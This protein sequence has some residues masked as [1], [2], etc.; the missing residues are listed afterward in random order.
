MLETE[1]SE[2]TAY[3]SFYEK[4]TVGNLFFQHLPSAEP[5]TVGPGQD[6]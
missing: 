6:G 1:N 2:F 4:K 5:G 3:H